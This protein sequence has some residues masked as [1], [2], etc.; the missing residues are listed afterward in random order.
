GGDLQSVLNKQWR[1]PEKETRI[2]GAQVL[3]GLEALH[4]RGIIHRDIKPANI[5]FTASGNVVIADLGL[6]KLFDSHMTAW[7]HTIQDLS[8][9]DIAEGD[10]EGTQKRCGTRDYMSP[11]I[12]RGEVYS[13]K[14][15]IWAYGVMLYRMLTGTVSL[16]VC[17]PV[18]RL[19]TGPYHRH[20]GFST[21]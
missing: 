10:D 1:I 17:F 11:E 12:Y 14:V 18:D 16:I 8:D 13:Y 6:A 19:L 15:D 7:E 4:A 9:E 3:S 20:L 2:I 5:L 21:P